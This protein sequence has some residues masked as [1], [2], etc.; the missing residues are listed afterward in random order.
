MLITQISPQTKDPLW[1]NVYLDGK[2]GFGIAAEN[3]FEHRLKAGQSLTEKEIH[4]LVFEDQ[5][6][7]LLNSAQNFLSFRPRSIR[8]VRDH[9]KRKLDKG[10]YVEPEKILDEVV[11]KLTKLGLL[12]DEE[13]TK[14]W[15][16]Q[17]QKFKPRGE[18]LLRSE[19]HAKGIDRELIDEQ[20]YNYRSPA[21]EIDKVAQKKLNSY[22]N[23]PE[24]E[25]RAKMG[26]F[27]ARRGYD[28]DEV[29]EVVD[30]LV[31][32]R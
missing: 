2:F 14:W 15:I 27:L 9:L 12:N 11:V 19:L 20:F 1:E 13:F 7:K 18:R 4:D 17:R 26:A 16:E 28:W 10:E 5:V 32:T 22:K 24:R 21:K 29:S 30:R 31:R 8:E 3:R 23:L 25:F 6:G